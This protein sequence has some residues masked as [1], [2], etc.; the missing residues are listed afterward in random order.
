MQ[1]GCDKQYI[2]PLYI[3]SVYGKVLTAREIMKTYVWRS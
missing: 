3:H 2:G 1:V